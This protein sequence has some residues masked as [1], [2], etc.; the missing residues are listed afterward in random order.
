MAF[1]LRNGVK[2]WPNGLLVVE[3][4]SGLESSNPQL[5]RNIADALSILSNST[6]WRVRRRS[7]DK[8]YVKFLEKK[9]LDVG[10]RVDESGNVG[11]EQ[12]IELN[13][14]ATVG[15]VLHEI[16]HKL[17][18]QHEQ[19]RPDRDLYVNIHFNNIARDQQHNYERLDY[20]KHLTHGDFDFDSI[21][22]YSPIS[23]VDGHIYGWRPGI[24][25]TLAIPGKTDF[26]V[27]L[28][29]GSASG[30][31]TVYAT[32]FDKG[33]LLSEYSR[34][35]VPPGFDVMTWAGLT[36]KRS[37]IF[38]NS[39]SGATEI[40]RFHN[41]GTFDAPLRGANL[42][43][44]F[45]RATAFRATNRNHCL[46]LSNPKT[47]DVQIRPFDFNSQE[48]GEPIFTDR[49]RPGWDVACFYRMGNRVFGLFS[50]SSDGTVS[51]HRMTRRGEVGDHVGVQN[52]SSGWA[53]IHPFK[54]RGKR[55][56]LF[57]LVYNARTARV[58]V[59]EFLDNGML[60][61]RISLINTDDW[62]DGWSDMDMM[63]T[64]TGRNFLVAHHPATGRVGVRSL[65]LNSQDTISVAP[66]QLPATTMTL[67]RGRASAPPH[68][69]ERDGE[70]TPQDIVAL[71]YRSGA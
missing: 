23:V 64:G 30:L 41:D 1:T 48:L 19:Q 29:P 63:V 50:K 61:N 27:A 56:R 58:N 54:L 70:L 69:R 44:R 43:G 12:T 33:F 5:F 66:V 8:T 17:G 25:K 59:H 21:M 46:F 40:R 45:T 55:D 6:N 38:I 51:V 26:V 65:F 35:A 15:M 71:N 28:R 37:I 22:M 14:I 57:A 67:L 52:W 3:V 47:G 24:V 62:S 11:G 68:N 16:C 9:G 49:W 20:S 13:P 10:G 7:K 42:N 32:K 60:D 4:A 53:E 31:G 2:D 34:E 39:R 36:M 18:F